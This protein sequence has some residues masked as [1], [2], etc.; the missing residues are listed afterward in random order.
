MHELAATQ[1]MLAIALDAAR[2]A[3]AARVLSIDLVIG[4]LSTMVDD[5]V[6]LYF[7]VLSRGTPAEGARLVVRRVPGEATCLDCSA[8]WPAR[9]PLDPACPTCGGAFVRVAGGQQFLID[10]IEIDDAE[11]PEVAR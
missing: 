7:D 3:G 2:K 8:R 11:V 4:D 1:S 6:Q 9:A 10:S 5:S